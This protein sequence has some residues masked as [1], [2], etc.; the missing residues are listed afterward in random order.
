[1][2]K[3]VWGG[4]YEGCAS[5]CGRGVVEPSHNDE[6]QDFFTLDRLLSVAE[7]HDESNTSK[8]PIT[9][10]SHPLQLHTLS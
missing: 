10:Y 2:G 3:L 1:M 8:S 7:Y 9:P 6:G 5:F 4:C